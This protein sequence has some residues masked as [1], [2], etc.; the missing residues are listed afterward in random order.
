MAES[1]E[2]WAPRRRPPLPE[3]RDRKVMLGL[4]LALM[5]ATVVGVVTA[6]LLLAGT[7]RRQLDGPLD[8]SSQ[9]SACHIQ[10]PTD[11]AAADACIASLP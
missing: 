5:A 9:I 10:Y 6:M 7:D 11:E 2:G 4:T 3:D 1:L 8:P